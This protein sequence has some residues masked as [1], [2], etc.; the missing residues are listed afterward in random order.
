MDYKGKNIDYYIE[1]DNQGKPVKYV[2]TD[3]T[4]AVFSI[5]G[6]TELEKTDVIEEK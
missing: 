5:K 3:G 4:F 2:F 6:K 1:L